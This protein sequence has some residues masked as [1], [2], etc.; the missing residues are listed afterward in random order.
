MSA[1]HLLCIITNEGKYHAGCNIIFRASLL[2]IDTADTNPFRYFAEYFDVETGQIYL[3]NRYYQPVTGRFTQLD[4][5]RDGLN[6]YAYCYNNPVAF[7]D[8]TGLSGFW[9][10]YRLG[11]EYDTNQKI[12]FAPKDCW[13]R[14]FGYTDI[15]DSIADKVIDIDTRKVFFEYGGKEWRIQ[16]WK[17][18]YGAVTG[19]E[20]GLYYKDIGSTGN[21][22]DCVQDSDMLTMSL[23][24]YD[25]NGIVFERETDKYWWC[26]GF[27]MNGGTPPE[28]LTVVGTITFKSKE[29]CNSFVD[30]YI[31]NYGASE[32][33][34]EDDGV[35]VTINW[36][37]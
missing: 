5:I 12:Y 11:F 13:Q 4:P 19:A 33:S 22:Y 16:F 18:D 32:I 21:K 24:L 31:N 14:K 2:N 20:I 15:Y 1:S 23:K 29:M 36:R 7:I 35:T 30:A 10:F 28:Q 9:S 25:S 34:V 26:N 37:G 6:W 17:G 27:K 3:R 8:Y